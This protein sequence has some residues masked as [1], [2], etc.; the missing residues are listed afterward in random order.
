MSSSVSD[1]QVPLA[2]SVLVA[3]D[4]LAVELADGRTISV[5]L[6]WY[7]R[8]WHGTGPERSRWRLIGHGHGIHWPDL[9]EDISVE[10]LLQGRP[11]GES[12][13]SL[14]QWLASRAPSRNGDEV[15]TPDPPLTAS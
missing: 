6:T 4:A 1:I 10:G 5:P 2:L 8:L 3:E 14:K 11:S 13:H 15:T 7:P 12:Q 9:D